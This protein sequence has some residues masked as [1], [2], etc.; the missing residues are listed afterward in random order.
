MYS[1]MV[2]AR[3]RRSG[4]IHPCYHGGKRDSG[5]FRLPPNGHLLDKEVC[6]DKNSIYDCNEAEDLRLI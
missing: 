3:V 6:E 4:A 5:S 1:P 2:F